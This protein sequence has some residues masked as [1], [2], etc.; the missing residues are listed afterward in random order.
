MSFE[1]DNNSDIIPGSYV[2]VYLKTRKSEDCIAVPLESIVES[3]GVYSVFVKIEDD[4]FMKK[5]VELGMSDGVN[6]QILSGLD[7][8]EELVT[9]GAMQIKL[10]SVSAVPSGHNHLH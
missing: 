3:Q 7:E 1:L 9:K 2:E 5:D 10:A 4:A 6:V 8:G